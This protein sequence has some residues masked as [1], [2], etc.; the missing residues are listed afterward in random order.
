MKP[1]AGIG[2]SDRDDNH[3][4]YVVTGITRKVIDFL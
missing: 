4:I 2:N 3:E 1:N